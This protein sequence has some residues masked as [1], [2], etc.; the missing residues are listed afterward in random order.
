MGT[1]GT[2]MGCSRFFRE[3]A[4]GVQIIGVQPEEGSTIPGIRRWPQEYLP[5]IYQP[6]HVDRIIDVSQ[7]AA[8]AMSLRLASDEGLFCGVS[9][10]GAL[11]VAVQLAEQ[12]ENAH[13]VS[14]ACDRG[15]RYLSTNLFNRA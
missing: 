11:W 1:T 4:P 8:E 10:G 9:S 12:L 14:I 5:K 15:D 13:I 3:T 7:Q 6:D 2:I